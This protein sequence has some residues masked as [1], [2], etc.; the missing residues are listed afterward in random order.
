M[1]TKLRLAFVLCLVGGL[2]VSPADVFAQTSQGG[3][4]GGQVVDESGGV[5]PGVA[6]TLVSEERGY[7][8]DLVTDEQGKYLFPVVPLGTYTIKASLQGFQSVVRTGNKVESERTTNVP[9][10]LK[11]A[12]QDVEVT[13]VGETPVVDMTNVA[14]QTRVRDKEFQKLPVGRNYQSL[15]GAAPGVV[16]TG[17]V[18]S[19][20]ALGS[21]NLFMFD[22]VNTTDPTTGTF[23]ANLNF[24]A[25]QEVVIFTSGVSAEYGRAVGAVVNVITKSGTNRFEGSAKYIATNDEWNKLESTKSETTGASLKRDP[26]DQI[27]PVY[28]FT[29]G[30]P[31]LRNRAWFFGTYERASTLSPQ[32]Q[33]TGQT[34]EDFQ[35]KV[36]SPFRTF[37]ASGQIT[38]NH[39]V[40]VK[41]TDSPSTGF[42]VTYW[43]ANTGERF[44]LTAQDQT[45]NHVAAQYSGVFG[46]SFTG[47]LMFADADET[48]TVVPFEV[49]PLHGG[50]PHIS[51]ADG[52][53]YNGATFDGAVVRPRR[54][55]SGALTWFTT[56]GQNSHSIKA[57]VDW[58]RMTSSNDFKFP[59]ATLYIDRSFNQATREFV[60]FLRRDYDSGASASKGDSWAF[61]LRDKFALGRRI[62]IEAGVRLETQ[63]GRSDVDASTV[64][65]FT[66][67]PRFS[68]AYDLSGTGKSLIVASAGRFYQGILQG[69]SDAFAAVPQITNYNQFVWNGSQYVFSNRFEAGAKTFKPNTDLEPTYTDEFTV[70]YEQQ[71][72]QTIGVGVRY[73]HR[74]WGNLIDDVWTFQGTTPVREVIN[75]GGAERTYR[76]LE[77]TLDKRFSNNWNASGSYT[78]S[79]AE[80]NHYD[81][82]F[83]SLGDFLDADCRIEGDPGVG[84][85]GVVP[86]RDVTEGNQF[87]RP[88]FDR[89]HSLKLAGAYSRPFGPVNLTL[90]AIYNAISKTTFTRTRTASVLTPGST[91]SAATRTYLYEPAGSNRVPG[92]S[93]QLDSSF[94]ATFRPY[95]RA[96]VGLKAEAFNV[97]NNEEK[98][99]IGS[100]VW[101]ESTATAACNT[102]RENFGKATARGHF[103]TPR[104]FRFTAIF[105]F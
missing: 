12:A 62:A 36:V 98:L 35:Q 53:T 95:R 7:T 69:F 30:G 46:S 40:W 60:P 84:A 102:A 43:G 19:H 49:S 8:R 54:Q 81:N 77:L 47:E 65:T 79:R 51:L 39:N 42:V 14:V 100:T 105:R 4:I 90:G 66:V 99:G 52:K 1:M 71:F 91:R 24:E 41:Y 37:R 82:A 101:C 75:Y 70:G 25:I 55:A 104:T 3:Q 44:A 5:M 61:Y 48:I 88:G 33:T 58:Q 28:S 87:G 31:I 11:V 56:L 96:E 6:V 20:G 83:S 34:P 17:N 89:P 27:N 97:L 15:I 22:G 29:A 45:T 78:R 67:S 73:I 9:L 50:A 103:N 74:T 13:V 76:G 18:S 85:S 2:L 63:T 80:G 64:D 93:N 86:C 57:G 68:G 92:L 23:G 10:V 94:E 21:N 32:R 38:P 72:G 59:T 26:F 16:G